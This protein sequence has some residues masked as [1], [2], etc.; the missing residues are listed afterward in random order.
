M[1]WHD[2]LPNFSGHLN[3]VT[4]KLTKMNSE[5]MG[6]RPQFI[7]YREL[8]KEAEELERQVHA[9]VALARNALDERQINN[10][11]VDL[12][13]IYSDVPLWEMIQEIARQVVDIRIVELE[14]ILE[15]LG[16]KMSRQAIESA[17]NTHLDKFKITKRGRE[18]FVALK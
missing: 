14:T 13:G 9:I 10:I 3:S 8:S 18:K 6:L 11:S 2:L 15:S 5:L 16:H 12:P 1:A 17:I 7:R 4:D